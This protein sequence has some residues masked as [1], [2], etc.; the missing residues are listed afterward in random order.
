MR[1]QQQLNHARELERALETWDRHNGGENGDLEH[2]AAVTLAQA[3]RNLLGSSI[4]LEPG[5]RVRMTMWHGDD[6][7]TGPHD[8]YMQAIPAAGDRI[9]TTGGILI[10]NTVYWNFEPAIPADVVL[11]LITEEEER[12][13]RFE[14]G[15]DPQC[16]GCGN[17]YSS[18]C[19]D[20]LE[21]PIGRGDKGE[22]VFSTTKRFDA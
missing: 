16:N 8:R 4:T 7:S 5:I 2:E 11:E 6:P 14:S 15:E 10:V 20:D 3:A 12:A 13:Q 18:H 21:C 17:L 1:N 22:I 9:N 19:S